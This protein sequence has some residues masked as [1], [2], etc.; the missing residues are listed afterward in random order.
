MPL[1]PVVDTE[2][3]P[4]VKGALDRT[5]K[6]PRWAIKGVKGVPKAQLRAGTRVCTEQTHGK[7]CYTEIRATIPD[8][9][10]LIWRYHS[11]SPPSGHGLGSS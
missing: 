1:G 7:Q 10:I 11:L 5:C 8:L 9:S 6:R 3:V 2:K 4:Y